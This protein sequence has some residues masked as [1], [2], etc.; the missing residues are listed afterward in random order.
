M[1]EA[2]DAPRFFH[3]QLVQLLVLLHYQLAIRPKDIRDLRRGCENRSKLVSRGAAA[4]GVAGLALVKEG[5]SQSEVE[6]KDGGKVG[7]DDVKG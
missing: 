6:A 4:T 7:K 2:I 5:G 3:L 1:D